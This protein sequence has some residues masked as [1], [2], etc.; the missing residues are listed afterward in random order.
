[1]NYEDLIKLLDQSSAFDL[2]RLSLILDDMIDDPRRIIQAKS[3]L[4]LGQQV[5]FLDGKTH[6]ITRVTVIQIKQTRI[7]AKDETGRTWD[8]P[9]CAIN[10]ADTDSTLSEIGQSSNAS[11]ADFAKGDHVAF[12]DQNGMEH[13][14]KIIRLNRKTAT[15]QTSE[16]EWRVDYVFLNKVIEVEQQ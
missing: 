14:G 2:Y 7:K 6:Q 5:D 9:L 1:M 10:T 12:S 13:T 16:G 15:I 11:K 8:L 4:R 3:K